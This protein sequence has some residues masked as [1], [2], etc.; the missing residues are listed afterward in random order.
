MFRIVST[1]KPKALKLPVVTDGRLAMRF[2]REVGMSGKCYFG[3]ASASRLFSAS[4]RAF[5]SLRFATSFC[6]SSAS[7][8][9][10]S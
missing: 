6:R 5:S 3:L 1:V 10:R 8:T 9:L 4:L 2:Y 7:L